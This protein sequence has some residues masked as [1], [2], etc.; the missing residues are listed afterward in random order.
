MFEMV[1]FKDGQREKY[2]CIFQIKRAKGKRE[3]I[4]S[5]RTVVNEALIDDSQQ[6]FPLNTF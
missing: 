3:T 5:T 6:P 1:Y 2:D 4:S